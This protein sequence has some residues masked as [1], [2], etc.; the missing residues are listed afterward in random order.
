VEVPLSAEPIPRTSSIS[1]STTA[2]KS[3]CKLANATLIPIQPEPVNVGQGLPPKLNGCSG[4]FRPTALPLGDLMP[5]FAL[6]LIGFVAPGGVFASA[7]ASSGLKAT[8]ASWVRQVLY[9]PVKT[10]NKLCPRP[11]PIL[12]K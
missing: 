4:V 11:E 1:C 5:I 3:P 10:K 2:T 8:V 7:T 9:G 12:K 6:P